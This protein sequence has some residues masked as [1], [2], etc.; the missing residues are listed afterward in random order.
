MQWW[1]C[2][3]CYNIHRPSQM[4]LS[5]VRMHSCCGLWW[6]QSNFKQLG[7]HP[8]NSHL[9]TLLWL[10]IDPSSS[11]HM[12]SRASAPWQYFQESNCKLS[13]ALIP[14][15]LTGSLVRQPE[16]RLSLALLHSTGIF[17]LTSHSLPPSTGSLWSLHLKRAI[18]PSFR[19]TVCLL[20]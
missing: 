1:K 12:L 9:A 11:A 20:A 14:C 3:L 5:H 19:Y 16:T 2:V 10:V 8:T 17:L 6:L 7:Q 18:Q 15:T 13:R 4:V